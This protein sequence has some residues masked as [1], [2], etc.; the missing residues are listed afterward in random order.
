MTE[1]LNS[2]KYKIIKEIYDT[3]KKYLEDLKKLHEV[4]LFSNNKGLFAYKK[5]N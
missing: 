3:E 2:E 4:R 5:F 1:F